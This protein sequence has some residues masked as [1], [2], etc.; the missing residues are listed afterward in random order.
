MKNNTITRYICNSC[1]FV[2]T[3]W[4]GHC[5]KCGNWNSFSEEQIQKKNT[6]KKS[7]EDSNKIEKLSE[8]KEEEDFRFSSGISELDR[9][10]GGGITTGSTILLGG[11]PGIGKSTLML[12]S[13]ASC[14]KNMKALFVA[15]E[16]NSSQIKHRALR[17]KLDLEN[18]LV[19]CSTNLETII[20]TIHK[21]KP[22]VI[23]VDSLQTIGSEEIS[24][25]SGSVSQIKACALELVQTA[26]SVNSAIFLVGH[27]TKE[28]LLAG[29]KVV[30][31]L[32]DTVVYFDQATSGIRF[33]RATKNRFGSIDEVGIFKMEKEG[34]VGVK[35]PSSFFISEREAGELPPG[36]SFTSVIEGSRTFLI[37][38]QALI[39]PAKSGYSR[40]Y[41]DKI[42]N[43]RVMR[44]AAILE[45]HGGVILSDKDIY[46]NVAGGIK[47][48]EVSIELALAMALWSASVNKSL[49]EKMVCF[50]ELS[51]AGEVRPVNFATKRE[52]AALNF[53]FD[54]AL[55]PKIGM[56][57][58]KGLTY[59][60]CNTISDALN[61]K[62]S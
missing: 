40:V 46:V 47:V 41:S 60:Q 35:D 54:K 3:K 55:V 52:K 8:I 49:P 1:G 19:L 25:I 28:G 18:I 27:V 9:V 51:L 15:G 5:P 37:E 7:S 24:A 57:N 34:L 30:E 56:K 2:S 44:V 62:L 23:V 31:H 14:A 11:E 20:N 39:I 58:I 42:D 6:N 10:L 61:I 38:I 4:L 32:V 33:I 26:K 50:G 21:E 59:R 13:I 16:E 45:R 43:R 17:L 48:N 36:I 29:P 12:Q 53:G 22:K